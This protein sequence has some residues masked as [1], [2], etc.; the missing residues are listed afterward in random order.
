[1]RV[2]KFR[3][4]GWC[5]IREFKMRGRDI[6]I[7]IDAGRSETLTIKPVINGGEPWDFG[8]QTVS[9]E[10]RDVRTDELVEALACGVTEEGL[11]VIDFPVREGGQYVFAVDM[12]GPDGGSTRLIDGYV[13]YGE[14]KAVIEGGDET[15][16]HCLTV[17]VDEKTRKAV[18]SWSKEAERMYEAAK[19]E[20]EKAAASADKAEKAANSVNGSIQVQLLGDVNAALKEFDTKVSNAIQVNAETNTWWIAGVD[21]KVQVTGDKGDA[22][23]SPY[24]NS[25]G[26]WVIWDAV[27][28]TTVDSGIKAQGIDGVDG[29]AVRRVLIDAVDD[30][31]SL[32]TNDKEAEKLRGVFYMAPAIEGYDVY[33][34]LETANGGYAWVNVGDSNAIASSVL[35]GL[36]KLGNSTINHGATVGVNAEGGL[37]T[38]IAK[39]DECGTVKPSFNGMPDETYCIGIT[40]DGKLQANKASLHSYG[41]VRLGS[42]LSQVAS[43]PYLLSV[44]AIVN[45]GTSDDGKMANNLLIGGA[46]KHMRTGSGNNGWNPDTVN[47]ADYDALVENTFY[48]GLHASSSFTQD[49]VNG[50]QLNEATASVKGGVYIGSGIDDTRANTVL[51]PSQ[52]KQSIIDALDGYCQKGDVYSKED[53]DNAI[54]SAYDGIK[55]EITQEIFIEVTEDEY[56][57][58]TAPLPNVLYLIPEP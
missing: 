22:G 29:I 13:T 43:I 16:D 57:K 35:Y 15:E 11:I 20:A 41:V 23:F 51:T 5:G 50:L 45:T 18:W 37:A 42:S 40:T 3:A 46:L 47:G 6:N 19:N 30:L 33:G 27:K 38:P 36:V 25:Q 49:N 24:I 44:G 10:L 53:V 54:N 7:D 52:I 58:I 8:S 2:R 4:E 56:A 21:T 12:S 39:A 32:P 55:D 1:M 9:G 34:L 48:L 31:P 17:Y 28:G 14:P 26:N